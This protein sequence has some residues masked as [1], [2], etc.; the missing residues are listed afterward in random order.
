MRNLTNLRVNSGGASNEV[1]PNSESKHK[2]KGPFLPLLEV[3]TVGT[4]VL[5]F[6]V[7]MYK[8]V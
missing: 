1:R 3:P 4:L 6:N 7:S 2:Y 5:K 8:Y